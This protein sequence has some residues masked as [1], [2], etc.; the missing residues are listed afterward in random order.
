MHTVL[1][2]KATRTPQLVEAGLTPDAAIDAANAL[3]DTTKMLSNHG[4][5]ASGVSVIVMTDADAE[6]AIASGRLPFR[7][8]GKDSVLVHQC[9][10]F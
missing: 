3:Y 4:L 9:G 8:V 5:L 7:V 1:T 6:T 10:G 2:Y